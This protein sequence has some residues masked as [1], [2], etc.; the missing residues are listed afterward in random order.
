MAVTVC[1]IF[2]NTVICACCS[3]ALQ[4]IDIAT[5]GTKYNNITNSVLLIKFSVKPLMPSS[6]DC[7]VINTYK[8]T[9][10]LKPL[11][12]RKKLEFKAQ[13]H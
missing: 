4:I 2:F 13:H 5:N 3:F 10:N 8:G 1:T 12:P 6:L 11:H 9:I 7:T